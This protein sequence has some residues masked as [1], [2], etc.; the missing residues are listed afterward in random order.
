MASRFFEAIRIRSKETD[1]EEA[2]GGEIIKAS[3]D[4]LPVL[5]LP[6][7]PR[8]WGAFH[9]SGYWIAE[10]F[11]I[12]QYQVASTAVAGGLS[13]GATIGAVFL[14]HV[15]VSVACALN[16][17]TGAVYG[18]NFPV[19]ARASFGIR[20]TS[21]AVICRAVAAIIW[22]GTQTYQGGQCVEVMLR[23]I[24]PSFTSFPNHLPASAHVTSS[25]LLCFFIFY[26]IQLPLLWIHISK[27]RYLFMVKVILMPIFG[28]ALF[29]WAVGSA[30]GFGPVFSQGTNPT[31]SP[32]A[33]LF[34][35]AMTSAIASKATLA[36]NIS[37]FTRYARS[38]KTVVWTN[39]LSLSIPVTLCAILGVVVT[40]A[41]QVIYGVTTWNPLQVCYLWDNR[42]AQFFTALCWAL[43]VIATN[44]SANST[45][46]GNDLTI[47]LPQFINIR[48]GQYICAILGVAAC[49]WIIQNSAASFTSFLGGYSIFL[50]PICGIIL[51]D[52]FILRRGKLELAQLYYKGS[53]D[54]WYSGGF[55]WRAL[56]S[57]AFAL[58]PNL[59]GFAGKVNANLGIPLGAEYL[60]SVVWPLGVAVS[61]VFYLILSF[62]F[63]PQITPRRGVE[64]G[65]SPTDSMNE[66]KV[67]SII[68]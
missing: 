28:L 62:V 37:D 56:V 35:S 64:Q 1:H 61:G 32:A 63:P 49:P 34:F 2:R 57:F 24:W 39:I 3:P 38:P 54:Y 19:Y 65:S 17:W 60:F 4:L 58:V 29:G 5:P 66:E 59:P 44:I 10:A 43:A 52:N 48:R 7:G 12:S 51:T 53:G 46:V 42:A 14:G 31:S 27:L 25:Q 26:I 30:R 16:G 9:L 50:G 68:I 20:G 6:D 18:I 67:S 23:A 47:L 41:V 40:S 45:A 22:F 33:I 21:V 8:R 15:L 11:G 36:L 13:P 55:N